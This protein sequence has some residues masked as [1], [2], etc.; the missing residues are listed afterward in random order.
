MLEGC[1]AWIVNS[2]S[3][4]RNDEELV[5]S[6]ILLEPRVALFLGEAIRQPVVDIRFANRELHGAKNQKG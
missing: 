4:P 3:R 6:E 5:I 2:T 1:Q